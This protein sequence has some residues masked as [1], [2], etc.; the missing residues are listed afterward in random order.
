MCGNNDTANNQSV[1]DMESKHFRVIWDN[2]DVTNFPA[3]W[4]SNMPHATLRN[5]EECWK[6]HIWL[7]GYT[8]PSQS[9]NPGSRNGNKYKVN[10]TM[11]YGG[12]FSGG[13]AGSRRGAPQQRVRGCHPYSRHN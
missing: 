10:L 2:W 9:W 11:F 1:M 3:F 12:Y 8:E 6:T 5:L 4:N 13:D 7:L